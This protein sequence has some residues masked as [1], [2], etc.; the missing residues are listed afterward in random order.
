M[1]DKILLEA[2]NK[3][4]EIEES[5]DDAKWMQHVNLD[6]LE[7][8]DV[9]YSPF[10][11][12]YERRGLE[13]AFFNPDYEGARDLTDDELWDFG[14][15]NPEILKQLRAGDLDPNILR[16]KGEAARHER[17]NKDFGNWEESKYPNMQSSAR[18][19][20]GEDE[21]THTDEISAIAQLIADRTEHENS[22]SKLSTKAFVDMANKMGLALTPET[23][24]DMKER[25]E[26]DEVIKDIN[27]DEV[28]FKGQQEIDD[29]AM[30]VDKAR[31]TVD[32]MAKRAAKRGIHK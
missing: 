18:I 2:F 8:E 10:G 29:S 13:S 25:G 4:K 19:N 28:Q 7:L 16:D 11:D 22:P 26:I 12:A 5:E 21:S 32:K 9:P 31:A 17:D 24:M 3:I 27:L 6:S 15:N 14:Y 23:L 1:T 20:E 30:N